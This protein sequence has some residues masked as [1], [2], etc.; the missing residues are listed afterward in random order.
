VFASTVLDARVPDPNI[1]RDPSPLTRNLLTRGVWTGFTNGTELDA[2]HTGGVAVSR[3]PFHPIDR[4]DRPNTSLY[5]LG[6]PTEH[7]RWFTLVGSGRPGPWNEFTRDADAI[8]ADALAQVT[9]T[10]VRPIVP[11]G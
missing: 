8:A 5:V 11:V 6:I 7:T 4:H 10:A 2:F 1:F 9:T 3:S